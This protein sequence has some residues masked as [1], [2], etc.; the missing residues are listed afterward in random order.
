MAMKLWLILCTLREIFQQIGSIKNGDENEGQ[1]AEVK[2]EIAS[3]K[4]A[5]F[6]RNLLA[7]SPEDLIR[8]NEESFLR[9]TIAAFPYKQSMMYQGLAKQIKD[10]S[11]GNLPSAFTIICTALL[12]S[13]AVETAHFWFLYI[14][15]N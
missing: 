5:Q 4:L 3:S 6:A 10:V 1:Q 14:Y 13:R 8:Q 15:F 2:S 11:F 12:G 7:M 9:T